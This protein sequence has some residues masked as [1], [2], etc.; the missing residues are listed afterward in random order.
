MGRSARGNLSNP[1]GTM[2]LWRCLHALKVTRQVRLAEIA[3][4]SCSASG[5]LTASPAR[6][7]LPSI[8]LLNQHFGI[9]C[10][11]RFTDHLQLLLR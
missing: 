5:S 10:T 3:L 1:F 6:L 7:E 11:F 2:L 9:A 8:R 4:R